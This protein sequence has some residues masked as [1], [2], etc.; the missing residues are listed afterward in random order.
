MWTAPIDKHFLTL[1]T[2]DRLRSYVRPVGAEK[3][4]AGPDEV[5]RRRLL[6]KERALTL[7]TCKAEYPTSSVSTRLVHHI[8]RACQT[9]TRRAYL[10]VVN[11]Y[12]G[13]YAFANASIR[14]D[15]PVVMIAHVIRAS[16]LASATVTSL[17]G[18]RAR[19]NRVALLSVCPPGLAKMSRQAPGVALYRR[20]PVWLWS[21]A[22]LCRRSSFAEGLIRAT[23][24]SHAPT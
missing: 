4:S 8:N 16:L 11:S 10:R 20:C 18:L 2:L 3:E 5:R 15:S 1:R 12:E 6:S 13:L 22:F 9:L 14:K 24:K 21:Q 19:P 7:M 17:A 23:R